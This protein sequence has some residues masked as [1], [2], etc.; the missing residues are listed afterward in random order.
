V[1]AGV[2]SW[3]CVLLSAGTSMAAGTDVPAV[4]R[5]EQGKESFAQRDCVKT[6][7][8]L[9][10][11]AVPGQLPDEKAQQDVHRMLGICRATQGE[12]RLAAREFA[13]LLAIDPDAQLDAFEVPPDVVAQF[14]AQKAVM[15]QQ[16][17]AVR[18]LRDNGTAAAETVAVETVIERRSIPTA[19]AL[20]PFGVPQWQAGSTTWAVVLG[21]AQGT[22]LLANVVGYWGSVTVQR[23]RVDG[24]TRG[25]VIADNAFFWTHV[26]GLVGFVATY[27]VGVGQALSLPEAEPVVVSRKQRPLRSDDERAVR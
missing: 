3:L 9:D 19:L 13:S 23:G 27:A 2:V 4:A 8:H 16:L 10:D 7:E 1:L 11:L 6:I 17:D 24:V 22:F 21:A 25:E 20:V 5:Y 14:D 26:A 18:Q 12:T 15:K